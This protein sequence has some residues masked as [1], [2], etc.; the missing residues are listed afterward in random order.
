MSLCLPQR[1]R[2]ARWLAIGY[3]VLLFLWLAPED[4]S[5]LPVT[6]LGG[7]LSA[8][9]VV[10]WM[11]GKLGGRAIPAR[12]AVL[13]AVLLGIGI[14]LGASVATFSLMLL[15]DAQHSHIY[16]D[17]PPALMLAILA[18]APAWAAAG[19]LAGFGAALAWLGLRRT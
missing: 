16:P 2:R 7:G 15:K 1:G 19:G 12:Y 14:G 6:L 9:A 11:L 4:N 18:R 13:G 5:I 17:F 3:G 10:L 8:L